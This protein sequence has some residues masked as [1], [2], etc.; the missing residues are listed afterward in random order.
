MTEAVF[1]RMEA[2]RHSPQR[3]TPYH[4]TRAGQ[5]HPN[6]FGEPGLLQGSVCPSCGSEDRAELA[7]VPGRNGPVSCSD[8]WHDEDAVSPGDHTSADPG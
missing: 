3:E 4:L 5:S 7:Y 6:E 2:E 8:D 1:W